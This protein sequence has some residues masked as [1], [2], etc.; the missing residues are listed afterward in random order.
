[1]EL[2]YKIFGKGKPIIILHGLFGMLDNWQQFAKQLANNYLV[3]ILDLRN[4]GKSPHSE[5][6][7]YNLMVKD[8]FQFI[9][10]HN[11]KSPHL[12]GHSM[13]GKVAIQFAYEYPS[14]IDKLVVIDIGLKKYKPKHNLILKALNSLNLEV[15][16]NR[17]Q[18]DNTLSEVIPNWNIRQFLIK[19]IAKNNSS[20]GYHWKLNLESI[21]KNYHLIIDELDFSKSIECQCLFIKGQNSD[22][23]LD[24][25]KAGII[26]ILPNSQF[27]T[28]PNAGHWVHAEQLK[29]LLEQIRNYF[30]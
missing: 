26:K 14:L 22:Y 23:I 28:I 19:N 10:T 18:I 30:K 15:F 17:K 3:Y 24:E 20:Q 13:G 16:S 4:H 6:F 9:N 21:T 25:D 8:I 29:Y 27:I 5:S 12:I 7:D 2:N 11:I 1:M